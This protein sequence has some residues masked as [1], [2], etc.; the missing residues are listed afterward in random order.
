MA[1]KQGAAKKQIGRL[2]RTVDKS[3][4]PV[5]PLCECIIVAECEDDVVDH[6][7]E[8]PG[9]TYTFPVIESEIPASEQ[10]RVVLISET[11]PA[12]TTS[13]FSHADCEACLVQQQT[14]KQASA[15]CGNPADLRCPLCLDP[16][17]TNRYCKGGNNI[18][19]GVA[20]SDQCW[21]AMCEGC[22]LATL[23]IKKICP[24]CSALTAASNIH[25]L[26]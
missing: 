1:V 13:G 11:D 17:G 26:M 2:C 21:H 18:G 4:K 7:D 22:W 15:L 12:I 14:P 6:V 23:A 20:V 19:R 3:E 5:C 24:L 16:L 9:K 10:R 25:R 8:C